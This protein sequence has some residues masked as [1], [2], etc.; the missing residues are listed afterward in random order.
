[1]DVV[2]PAVRLVLV[3]ATLPEAVFGTLR[4][5]FPGI[6]AATGPNLHR[7]AVGALIR[8]LALLNAIPR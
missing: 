3:T 7:I 2:G 1:M 8:D 5:I 6:A 4:D